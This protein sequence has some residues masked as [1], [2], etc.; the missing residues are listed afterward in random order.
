M[1]SP[2]TEF[3]KAADELGS[4]YAIM[5]VIRSFLP[6]LAMGIVLLPLDL[7]GLHS[8]TPDRVYNRKDPVAVTH[9]VKDMV[10]VA[11]THIR[12]SRELSPSVPRSLRPCLAAPASVVENIISNVKKVNYNIYDPVLQ[13]QHPFLMWSLLAKRFLGRY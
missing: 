6:L 10:Q 7:L 12:T 13:K 5:N 2:T 8:L 9:V 4:A 1:G 11:L 3:V